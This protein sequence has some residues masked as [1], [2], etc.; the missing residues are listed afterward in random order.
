MDI[1]LL[2]KIAGIGILASVLHTVLDK[3]GKEEFAFISTLLAVVLVLGI[4]IKYI[5]QLFNNIK[6]LFKLY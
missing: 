3:A 4:V 5:S 6:T 2:F 1:D